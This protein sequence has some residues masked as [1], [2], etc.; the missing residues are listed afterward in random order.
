MIRFSCPACSSVLKAPARRAGDD[1]P[2]PKCAQLLHVPPESNAA[3]RAAVSPSSGQ[4]MV[5][6]TGCASPMVVPEG[7]MGEP[8]ECPSCKS[9]FTPLIGRSAPSLSLPPAP[10][11]EGKADGSTDR[12]VTLPSG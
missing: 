3:K 12:V 6:C 11:A 8:V 7:R 9:A 10:Q 4:V 5:D 1:V 2:C